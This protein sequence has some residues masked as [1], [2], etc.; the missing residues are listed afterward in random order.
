VE[1]DNT[2]RNE[3]L[4]KTGAA[5]AETQSS[6]PEDLALTRK[7]RTEV[8]SMKDISMNG[9]NIKIISNAGKVTLRGPVSNMTEKQ[10]IEE[11]AKKIAGAGNVETFI[12][13]IAR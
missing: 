11:A 3:A 2:K 1:A 9:K 5:T 8:V 12:E 4:E 10:A 6:A 13:V 7:I